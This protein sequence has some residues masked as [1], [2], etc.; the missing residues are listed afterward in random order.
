VL[1]YLNR[2]WTN[3]NEAL[4][5]IPGGFQ[6]A[7][8]KSRDIGRTITGGMRD[9]RQIRREVM[10]DAA[11]LTANPSIRKDAN[12]LWKA[13]LSAEMIGGEMSPYMAGGAIGGRVGAI[14]TGI[15]IIGT[16]ERTRLL[17][18]TDVSPAQA[19]GFGAI[20]GAIQSAIGSAVVIPGV[21]RGVIQKALAGQLIKRFGGRTIAGK[22]VEPMIQAASATITGGLGQAIVEQ[23][24]QAGVSEV[25]TQAAKAASGGEATLTNVPST[26]VRAARESVAPMTLLAAAGAGTQL[27]GAYRGVRLEKN[28][29]KVIDWAR[30]NQS[31]PE[32]LPTRSQWKGWGLPYATGMRKASRRAIVDDLYSVYESASNQVE[33]VISQYDKLGVAIETPEPGAVAAT[34]V[35]ITTEAAVLKPAVRPVTEEL[36]LRFK[37]SVDLASAYATESKRVSRMESENKVRMEHGH[38]PKPINAAPWFAEVS[39]QRRQGM[40][41]AHILANSDDA[42]V[43][44]RNAEA[45]VLREI[46]PK[47]TD[48]HQSVVDQFIPRHPGVEVQRFGDRT[49]WRMRPR[50]V[51]AVEGSPAAAP[52]PPEVA[53]QV[54]RNGLLASEEGTLTIEFGKEIHDEVAGMKGDDALAQIESSVSEARQA[55]RESFGIKPVAWTASVGQFLKQLGQSAVRRELHLPNTKFYGLAHA[56]L[57][58]IR[59]VPEI[60]A[61]QSVE[62]MRD[63][64]GDLGPLQYKLMSHYTFMRDAVRM[65]EENGRLPTGYKNKDQVAADYAKLQSLV[66]QTPSV[67]AS[68]TKLWDSRRSLFE[69]AVRAKLLPSSILENLEDYIHHQVLYYQGDMAQRRYSEDITGYKLS[70]QR[71][72]ANIGEGEAMAPWKQANVSLA[73]SEMAMRTELLA[74]ITLRKQK[75]ILE[76]GYDVMEQKQAEADA[77]GVSLE[78]LIEHDPNWRANQDAT[79]SFW[80]SKPGDELYETP[81]IQSR[82]AEACMEAGLEDGVTLSD[83]E[84]A[85]VMRMNGHAKT[86]LLPTPLVKQLN[87]L[88]KP[89]RNERLTR[90]ML[91]GVGYW[92]AYN[93]NNPHRVALFNIRNMSGDVEFVLSADPGVL[94]YAG[95][96]LRDMWKYHYRKQVTNDTVRRARDNGVISSG[97]SSEMAGVNPMMKLAVQGHKSHR[98]II[99]RYFDSAKQFSEFRESVLRYAAFLRYRDLM[100]KGTLKHYGASSRH[101]VETVRKYFGDEAA[102][103]KMSRELLGDYGGL[104]VMGNWLRSTGAMPF[105]A[106]QEI[107]LK[108]WPRVAINAIQSGKGSGRAA[109][110]L[111]AASAM[112]LGY[113]YAMYYCWNNLL[114]PTICG[115][116]L[117]QDLPEYVRRTAHVTLPGRDAKGRVRYVGNMGA[118]PQ[119]ADWL[120]GIDGMGEVIWKLANGDLT[121][122]DAKR[123]LID[124]GL[125]Q[126]LVGQTGPLKSAAELASG[127][128]FRDIQHPQQTP[129]GQQLASQAG[130]PETYQFYRQAVKKDGTRYNFTGVLYREADPRETAR[131]TVGDSVRSWS[132]KQGITRQEPIYPPSEFKPGVDAV[133]NG[134]LAAFH[135]WRRYITAGRHRGDDERAFASMVQHFRNIDPTQQLKET[136]RFDYEDSLSP[137]EQKQLDELRSYLME[138]EDTAAQWWEDSPM[139]PDPR[140]EAQER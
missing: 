123:I 14:A 30:E 136:D 68:L 15:P 11:Y 60:A 63:I 79:L 130:F 124:K 69:E 108:R 3:V 133:K 46:G 7:L 1:G 85:T 122:A 41:F 127:M 128:T 100:S 118:L 121:T 137:E 126:Q 33:N 94:R 8:V 140:I 67:Q 120:G 52:T 103:A 134:D 59:M 58:H 72:R 87:A 110:M 66:D 17:S 82:V 80:T 28:L 56:C 21:Q 55:Q 125:A 5:G 90:W 95:T 6:Q 36:P 26:M 106:F 54:K 10:F 84:L 91:R 119:A 138:L 34:V 37:T 31:T 62:Q 45:G 139:P 61:S 114:V 113:G 135:E 116:D 43:N 93:L 109:A 81:D 12:P 98:N 92:K 40:S 96:A 129:R 102:A 9:K 50:E 77:K 105:W 74:A 2:R 23:P 51:E 27:P 25:T 47:S 65:A 89:P 32:A 57:R 86:L 107:N 44:A 24:L 99:A 76:D 115:E 13:I 19:T 29:G 22:A 75:R 70:V 73:E 131:Q 38:Q 53:S 78:H 16:Q 88:K 71:K 49:Y 64:V 132:E 111:S 104:T 48:W 39:K 42:V 35:P 112:R 83:S 101:E 4:T 20:S 18:E 117:E 97:W